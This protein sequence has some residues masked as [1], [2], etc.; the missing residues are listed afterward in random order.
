MER[1]I[2]EGDEAQIESI[3]SSLNLGNQCWLH[4]VWQT[5]GLVEEVATSPNYFDGE[6]DAIQFSSKGIPKKQEMVPNLPV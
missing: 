1:E 2:S 3:F 6:V 5:P 4:Y